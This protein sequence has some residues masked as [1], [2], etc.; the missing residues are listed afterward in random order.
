MP[1]ELKEIGSEVAKIA[2]EV[3][4]DSLKGRM[5]GV[6]KR[7][8]KAA[9]ADTLAGITSDQIAASLARGAYAIHRHDAERKPVTKPEAVQPPRN[10]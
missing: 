9:A 3:S 2:D 7:A 10:K 1:E 6:A 4:R 5:P 8:G